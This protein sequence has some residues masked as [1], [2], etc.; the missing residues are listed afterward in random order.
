[1]FHAGVTRRD[2]QQFVV[3][4]GFIGHAEHTDGSAGNNNPRE[5]GLL[6]DH[7]GVQWIAIKTKGVVDKAVVVG[8]AG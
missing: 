2:A 4:A 5:G 1:M 8:V 6:H 3:T 7:Q